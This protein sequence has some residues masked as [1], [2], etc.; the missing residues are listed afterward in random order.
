MLYYTGSLPSDYVGRQKNLKIRFSK[1]KLLYV[2]FIMKPHE[3]SGCVNT[4]CV[5]IIK[6]I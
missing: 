5:C 1:S 4:H 3:T 2:S 6:G